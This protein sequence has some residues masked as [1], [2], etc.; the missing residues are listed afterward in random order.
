MFPGKELLLHYEP[1]YILDGNKISSPIELL[2]DGN[3][4]QITVYAYYDDMFHP[5]GRKAE[6]CFQSYEE[7]QAIYQQS[8]LA[9][10]G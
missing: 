10:P 8:L 2:K 1:D 6:M 4:M 7:M 5:D 9:G 3:G